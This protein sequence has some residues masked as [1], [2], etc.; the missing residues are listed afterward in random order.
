MRRRV[1]AIGLLVAVYFITGRLGLALAIGGEREI[2]L[3]PPAGICLAVL[4]LYGLDLWPGILIGSFVT[5]LSNGK[6]P[7]VALGIAVCVTL[8]A[9]VAALALRFAGFDPR[10]ARLR[11]VMAL[12][13]V[14]AVC[15]IIVAALGVTT[16][17]LAGNLDNAMYVVTMGG[18]WLTGF[19]SMIVIAPAVFVVHARRAHLLEA[20]AGLTEAMLLGTA[21]LVL[22]AFTFMPFNEDV[23]RLAKPYLMFL[24]LIWA[25][26]RFGALGAVLTSLVITAFAHVTIQLARHSHADIW[27]I[28]PYFAIVSLT[29]MSL[30]AV[31]A[32]RRSSERYKAA[33]LDAALD[34][35]VMIDSRGLICEANHRA[36]QLF[37]YK[38]D[39]LIGKPI[40]DT[41]IPRNANLEGLARFLYDGT[42]SSLGRR[43]RMPVRRK[44][45]SEF[46]AEISIVRVPLAGPPRFTGFIRDVTLE[47]H[48]EERTRRAQLDLEYKVRLRTTELSL[49]NAELASR[50]E[51]DAAAQQLAHVGSFDF[52]VETQRLT[53]SDELCRIYG[54]D[55]ATFTPT[56]AEL[57]SR[58][59]AAD[60]E[61]V[62]HT[63]ATA[64]AELSP[65]CVELRIVRPDGS[66]R[67]LQSHGKVVADAF[68]RPLRVLGSCQD[69]TDQR[70]AEL[71]RDRLARLVEFSDDGMISIDPQLSI[72]T[73]N[74]GATKLF[75][76]T[77]AEMI[78]QPVTI[79]VPADGVDNATD[80]LTKILANH[81]YNQY[82]CVLM[83]PDGQRFDAAVTSSAIRNHAGEII[84]IASV[85][86][87]VSQRTKIDAQLRASLQ[88]KEVLLR[89]IHHR[90]KNNLQVISSFLNLL[91]AKLSSADARRAMT[92]SQSRI[93]SMA[94]VHQLLYQSK[95]FASIDFGDYMRALAHRLLK[96][97]RPNGDVC[98][99]VESSV[100][101]EIDPAITC[102]LIVNE[103]LANALTHAFPNNRRGHVGVS[104]VCVNNRYMLDVADDGV[105]IPEDLSIDRVQSFGLKIARTLTQQLGGT[106]TLTRTA[107]TTVHLEFP[108]PAIANRSAA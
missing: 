108:L 77:A 3:W 28:Q 22:A 36:E 49:A 23:D 39:E 79:L 21:L 54:V 65:F 71:A 37:D 80:R 19:V 11:D 14:S 89:E 33:V 57:T 102:G 97:Y 12:L 13:I 20:G 93:Q 105:G 32:S 100:R 98:V 4:V 2:P 8:E 7:T 5:V 96:T 52:A 56:Y 78:G 26:V 59:Y 55:P 31:V 95:D 86:R 27:A 16:M 1:L 35:V 51:Q 47:V 75:D 103:L 61:T 6:V 43:M 45:G 64:I 87:D 66:I 29:G 44:D 48:A 94:L 72:E 17:L 42:T 91:I 40:T 76:R 70:S 83:R 50:R 67:V 60:R 101:L 10:L 62:E 41:L 34:A 73:W 24:P 53:W 107:G 104:L 82:E 84:G 18:W 88:E 58:I 46:P 9:L 30:A 63:I 99:D 38:L 85:V 74:S 81:H 68:G 92:E 69:V 90:V 106:L 15:S 25:A